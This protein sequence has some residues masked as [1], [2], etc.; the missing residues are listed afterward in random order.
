MTPGVGICPT[1]SISRVVLS[2][3]V[4][5]VRGDR[6]YTIDYHARNL[7]NWGINEVATDLTVNQGCVFYKLFTRAFPEHFTG[8]SIYAHYPMTIPSVTKDIMTTLKRSHNF[9]YERPSRAQVRLDLTSVC[10]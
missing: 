10:L 1:Y 6:F 3:A 9:S 4:S 8:N 7:T 5:L 2:D